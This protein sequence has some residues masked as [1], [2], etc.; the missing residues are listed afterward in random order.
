MDF[1]SY[2]GFKLI[3]TVLYRGRKHSYRRDVLLY[4][5]LY[6]GKTQYLVVDN[7]SFTQLRVDLNLS[8]D[9]GVNNPWATLNVRFLLLLHMT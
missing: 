4:T 8:P 9:E 2:H 6:M 5:L 7:R 3:L 1:L